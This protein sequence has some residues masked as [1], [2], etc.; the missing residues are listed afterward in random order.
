M[1]WAIIKHA[2]PLLFE[3]LL[4]TVKV[5]VLAI[6]LGTALGVLLGL[7]ALGRNRPLRWA[8]MIYVDFIR[9][10]PLLIQIFWFTSRCQSSAL[11]CRSSGR[12]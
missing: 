8:V 7:I 9:G 10:T 11:V 2:I 6:L 12:A 4:A 1:D 3:G 5:S